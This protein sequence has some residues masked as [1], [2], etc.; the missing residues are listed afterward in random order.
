MITLQIDPPR[1]PVL[2]AGVIAEEYDMPVVA[3]PDDF[4]TEIAVGRRGH[5]TRL[6]HPVDRCNPKIEHAVDWR[7][8]GYPRAISS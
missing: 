2:V 8:E 1:L 6:V 5:W 7:Q 4:G 3:R